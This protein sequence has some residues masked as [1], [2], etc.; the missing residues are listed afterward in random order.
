MNRVLTASKQYR[1]I[2]FL[3]PAFTVIAILTIYPLFYLLSISLSAKTLYGTGGFVGLANFITLFTDSL[4]HK[5]FLVTTCFIIFSTPLE[6]G[7]GLGLAL[8][9]NKIKS[10]YLG[11]LRGIFLVPL[12]MAPIAAASVWA[13]MFFPEGGTINTILNYFGLRGQAWLTHPISALICIIVVEVWQFTPFCALVSLGGLKG[14][15]EEIYESAAIDGSSAFKT[16]R[17]ITLPLMG[18]TIA[19][20]LFFSIMRQLKAFDVV[21]ALTKGGPEAGTNVVSFFI[22]EQAFRFYKIGY[23]AAASVIL[24]FVANIAG[25][26]F[27]RYIKKIT[28]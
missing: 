8:I 11:F 9:I 12:M 14:I 20:C 7:W 17:Y 19:L 4:F 25:V 23:A 22:Y 1:H 27:M 5:S 3:I 16:F 15:S 2:I 21:Y 13:L 6:V 24:L 26:F 18:P 28:S 10:R